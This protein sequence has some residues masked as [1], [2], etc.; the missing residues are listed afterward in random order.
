MDRF[1]APPEGELEVYFDDV[2][3]AQEQIW[4]TLENYKEVVEALEATNESVI[5]H[6]VNDILR[7][8]PDQRDRLAAHPARQPVGNERRPSGRGDSENSTWWSAA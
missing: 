2:V 8:S 5:S 4:D 1:L 6:R 3:D 7:F